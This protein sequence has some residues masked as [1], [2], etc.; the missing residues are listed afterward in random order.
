VPELV[1][2]QQNEMIDI[3]GYDWYEPAY[4]AA[5]MYPASSAAQCFDH[6]NCD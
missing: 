5:T 2:R 3:T 6:L 4:W 1:I